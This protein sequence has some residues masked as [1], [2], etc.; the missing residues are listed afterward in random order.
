L[1]KIFIFIKIQKKTYMYLFKQI[2]F[3]IT[4]HIKK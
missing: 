2:N 3:F 4:E 1:S